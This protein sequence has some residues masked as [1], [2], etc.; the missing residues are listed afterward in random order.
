MKAKKNRI[1]K[2]NCHPYLA[3]ALVVE[4]KYLVLRSN[5]REVF[6]KQG[7]YFPGCELDK[8]LDDKKQLKNQLYFK[9]RLHVKVGKCLGV[10]TS[11]ISKRK[12]CSLYLYRCALSET[13]TMS[14]ADVYPCLFSA[15]ELPSLK[16][17]PGD[18]ELA[19]RISIFD[20]VY[21]EVSRKTLLN[22]YDYNLSRLFYKCLVYNR[23]KIEY[24]DIA[25]FGRLLKMDSTI[26]EIEKAFVYISKRADFSLKEYIDMNKKLLKKEALGL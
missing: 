19:L 24:Q 2:F 23:A 14:T 16:F 5:S 8:N 25:D 1:N 13:T 21:R 3:A 18:D 15:H 22:E 26:E 11:Q 4:D 9:Y 10:G 20:K 7:Y 17:L 6:A 12:Y